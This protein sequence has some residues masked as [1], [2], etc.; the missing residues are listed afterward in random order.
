M[1]YYYRVI[2][3]L[4]SVGGGLFAVSEGFDRLSRGV[5]GQEVYA[6]F[7]IGGVLMLFGYLTYAAARRARDKA[8]AA[9]LAE[10][11][12]RS[13]ATRVVDYWKDGD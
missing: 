2:M 11:A 10:A 1:R 4:A 3:S 13:F 5:T 9:A 8:A 7:I 6:A 12:P